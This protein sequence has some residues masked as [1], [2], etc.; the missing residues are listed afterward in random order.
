M[1]AAAEG[2]HPGV[3]GI[4][5]ARLKERYERPACVVAVADG[6]GKGSGRSVPGVALGPAVIAARQAGLLVNGGGHAMAA[7]FT[8]AADR[9]D[10]LREF[11]AERLGDGIDRERLVPELLSIDGALSAAR[12]NRRTD[13]PYRRAG[14]VRRRQSRAALRLSRRSGWRMSSR[15]APAICA[16]RWPMPRSARAAARLNAIAFRV[17]DT[18]LGQFLA[19]SRGRAIHVAG[20]LR[21][22]TYRGGDAVQLVIDDAAP[23]A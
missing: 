3:I 5:A 17:A 23:A 6:I 13:R 1:F 10:A 16:A 12:R 22:D 8:V 15:S 9:L 7:G 18:P 2:W 20:H 14:A 19:A 11:L 21:R 4:V